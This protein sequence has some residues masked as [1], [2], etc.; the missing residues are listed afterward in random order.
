MTKTLVIGLDAA[1]WDILDPLLEDGRLPNFERLLD[2][3]ARGTL[4]STMP[5]MTPLAW[6]SIAT[7]VSPGEHGI[8]GFREQNPDTYE[9]SPVEYGSVSRPAV[10]DVID[11]HDGSVG[12]MNYPI[13]SPPPKV[14]GF[15]VSGFPGTDDGVRAYPSD[16]QERLRDSDFKVKPDRKPADDRKKYYEEVRRITDAQCQ[17]TID[18]LERYE[19]DLLWSVFMG[20]DWIQHYLWNTEIDGENAVKKSYEH[21]DGVLGKLLDSVGND[22]NVVLLSDH[23]AGEITGE[24]H[25]N[26]LLENLGYLER[27]QVNETAFE[28]VADIVLEACWRAGAALPHSAKERVKRLAPDSL[29]DD[30]RDA[31][32]EGRQKLKETIDWQNTTAFAYDS[33]GKIYLN[34]TDRYPDG[35]VT[36]DERDATL[37][38]IADRLEELCHPETG[39]EIVTAVHRGREIYSGSNAEAAPDLLV[40][41]A[42]WQYMCYGDFDESWFHTPRDR[43]ADHTPEGIAVIAGDAVKTTQF[44]ADCTSIAAVVL[45]LAGT[46]VPEQMNRELLSQLNGNQQFV[47]DDRYTSKVHSDN[48]T[49]GVEERLRDLGY[50]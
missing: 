50:R 36:P 21:F 37:T 10:W 12:I 29:L 13:V 3:G 49:E 11:A 33:M 30:V 44:T 1:T 35:M 8:Y 4:I 23:G 19:P 9:V 15:F 39:E 5:P 43:F 16:V 46:P 24:I 2:R 17:A 28:T 25:L 41:P 32:G 48:V 40:E 31:A 26:E 22:R 6:T 18:F 47:S 20:I 7:G 14:D 42:D 27:K 38:E 45:S 34:S